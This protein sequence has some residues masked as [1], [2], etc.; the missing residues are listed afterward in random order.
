MSLT[1][2][3]V[4]LVVAG[5]VAGV[6]TAGSLQ[7]GGLMADD[8]A[9]PSHR[10]DAPPSPQHD[11]NLKTIGGRT[12]RKVS[13]VRERRARTPRLIREPRIARQP[14]DPQQM[15]EERL[16]RHERWL[17][18]SPAEAVKQKSAFIDIYDPKA[19]TSLLQAS[20]NILAK[21]EP[22]M[23]GDWGALN[24][25][26]K[27][28]NP[29][30]MIYDTIDSFV[31]NLDGSD[32]DS[33]VQNVFVNPFKETNSIGEGFKAMGL[34]F[35]MAAGTDLDFLSNPIKGALA[36]GWRGF[37]RGLGL[38]G[39]GR[40]VYN[41]NIK[42]G[43]AT[44]DFFANLGMEL[45]VS[46]PTVVISS[47]GTAAKAGAK[48]TT[49]GAKQ[50]AKEVAQET[51]ERIVSVSAQQAA[52]EI[53]K[54]LTE[55]AA[56]QIIKQHG[57]EAVKGGV[58]ALQ[59]QAIEILAD[60]LEKELIKQLS[61]KT[62]KAT[63]QKVAI[64]AGEEAIQKVAKESGEQVLASA[65]KAVMNKWI[66]MGI[67]MSID[68]PAYKLVARATQT[69]S[70]SSKFL[71]MTTQ[72]IH[73]VK[74]TKAFQLYRF[75]EALMQP[76]R[77]WNKF[78]ADPISGFFLNIY[79]QPFKLAGTVVGRTVSFLPMTIRGN[80]TKWITE[81]P[82]IAKWIGRGAGGIANT[83]WAW[84][85]QNRLYKQ[86][87]EWNKFL[88]NI[89]NIDAYRQLKDILNMSSA[90]ME[91]STKA[92]L[93]LNGQMVHKL[94]K[95]APNRGQDTVQRVLKRSFYEDVNMYREIA[96]K[97]LSEL[98]QQTNEK[99]VTQFGLAQT[100]MSAE[101]SAFLQQKY[102]LNY[103]Q[104]LSFLNEIHT[105]DNNLDDILSMFEF[106]DL[107]VKNR[108]ALTALDNIEPVIISGTMTSS[109]KIEITSKRG[110]KQSA[111]EVAR[112][113]QVMK[114]SNNFIREEK[115]FTETN[116][117]KIP[118]TAEVIDRFIS[119]DQV[120]QYQ[121]ALDSFHRRFIEV[122]NMRSL[123]DKVNLFTKHIT[124]N[125]K[126]IDANA[127]SEAF[128]TA[129]YNL[130]MFYRT[131]GDD[132]ILARNIASAWI[133]EAQ[134]VFNNKYILEV[135][136][137]FKKI[138][139][140]V[141]GA[142]LS[143]QLTEQ[144]SAH[145]QLYLMTLDPQS[146]I[147]KTLS[148]FDNKRSFERYL[149]AAEYQ[150]K[151][152]YI[153]QI[154]QKYGMT[155][156]QLSEI[157]GYA[158]H[159][160]N[161]TNMML[162]DVKQNL[163]LIPELMRTNNVAEIA[164]VYSKV[165]SSTREL[166]TLIGE[167]ASDVLGLHVKA[168]RDGFELQKTA[169]RTQGNPKF[170]A[171]EAAR[172]T[173]ITELATQ[174]NIAVMDFAGQIK[175]QR[176]K[177]NQME[178]QYY[179]FNTFQRGGAGLSDISASKPIV[180]Q[181]GFEQQYLDLQ[182]QLRD[183]QIKINQVPFGTESAKLELQKAALESQLRKVPTDIEHKHLNA[184]RDN[185]ST[186]LNKIFRET[187]IDLTPAQL[188]EIVDSITW[189][190]FDRIRGI[191]ET[192][193]LPE[194]MRPSTR[195]GS[196]LRQ[197]FG[198]HLSDAELL[199]LRDLWDKRTT[200]QALRALRKYKP[201]ITE[202]ALAKIITGREQVIRGGLDEL[203]LQGT[204]A[205]RPIYAKNLGEMVNSEIM[206][207]VG[208]GM[209]ANDIA[210]S[211]F[212]DK[213]RNSSA[214]PR[215]SRSLSVG[216]AFIRRSTEGDIIE[217]GEGLIVGAAI[218]P[219]EQTILTETELLLRQGDPATW[220]EFFVGAKPSRERISIF[221]T[222][223]G[224]IPAL[225]D[226]AGWNQY[227][228]KFQNK[229]RK[230]ALAETPSIIVAG[231]RIPTG[232]PLSVF[233]DARDNQLML[234]IND[235]YWNMDMMWGHQLSMNP[236]EAMNE[237]WYTL[238]NRH[239]DLM[240]DL[241]I[242]ATTQISATEI[243][244]NITETAR[245]RIASAR[246]DLATHAEI[247]KVPT[248]ISGIER[249]LQSIRQ[250][251][252]A[253]EIDPIN[254][255]KQN[256]LK[257][258]T[259]NEINQLNEQS[260]LL[261]A[262]IARLRG[263][264]RQFKTSLRTTVELEEVIMRYE[265]WLKNIDD[266]VEGVLKNSIWPH[267][268]AF[269]NSRFKN[270]LQDLFQDQIGFKR[271]QGDSTFV[272]QDL[273][274]TSEILA[275]TSGTRVNEMGQTL[276][277]SSQLPIA[278][279]SRFQTDKLT[280]AQ[281]LSDAWKTEAIT[282]R[283][284]ELGMRSA[285]R[286]VY[287]EAEY[288]T[289]VKQLDEIISIRTDN[290]GRILDMSDISEV[291]QFLAFLQTSQ[292]LA[293]NTIITR[294]AT[295]NT[296]AVLRAHSQ[297]INELWE[298]FRKA[299]N[300]PENL[301][302]EYWQL[303][304]NS[305][306]NRNSVIKYGYMQSLLTLRLDDMNVNLVRQMKAQLNAAVSDLKTTPFG[307][308]QRRLHDFL[309][310]DSPI[311]SRDVVPGAAFSRVPE[312]EHRI[313][314]LSP[315]KD[316][317]VNFAV[318]TKEMAGAEARIKSVKNLNDLAALTGDNAWLRS[319]LNDFYKT[320]IRDEVN[321]HF[322]MIK[323]EELTILPKW[324]QALETYGPNNPDPSFRIFT[325]TDFE[326]FESWFYGTNVNDDT[327]IKNFKILEKNIE[328]YN[329]QLYR[330][331]EALELIKRNTMEFTRDKWKYQKE[332]L[333]GARTRLDEVQLYLD[334]TAK[335]R[336]MREAEAAADR[337]RL[338]SGG[339]HPL[340]LAEERIGE[341]LY[342]VEQDLA[343]SPYLNYW[344]HD[345]G[346]KRAIQNLRD[347]FEQPYTIRETSRPALRELTQSDRAQEL[348]DALQNLFEATGNVDKTFKEL[349]R[350]IRLTPE[351]LQKSMRITSQ[352]ILD[353]EKIILEHNSFV[354]HI[355]SGKNILTDAD[356][357]YKM[358]R[359]NQR[360]SEAYQQVYNTSMFNRQAWFS[361]NYRQ[362]ALNIIKTLPAE[363]GV[364]DLQ[365]LLNYREQQQAAFNLRSLTTTD[366]NDP[367]LVN[368]T[369]E[370]DHLDKIAEAYRYQGTF[371][372][373]EFINNVAEFQK[374]YAAMDGHSL[375][376]LNNPNL[377]S[378]SANESYIRALG[379][380]PAIRGGKVIPGDPL[381]FSEVHKAFR[382]RQ[383]GF[384]RNADQFIAG[385]IKEIF[386]K[387]ADELA[388]HLAFTGPFN[389]FQ[390]SYIRRHPEIYSANRWLGPNGK[391]TL[392][393][394][395]ELL[396]K[397][398][399]VSYLPQQDLMILTLEKS[400]MGYRR[401]DNAVTLNG[402][403]IERQWT[404][405]SL[406]AEGWEQFSQIVNNTTGTR[407]GYSFGDQV[408]N[409]FYSRLFTGTKK[410]FSGF[411]NSRGTIET[412]YDIGRRSR[413][414]Q[415]LLKE[416]YSPEA[417]T[418]KG[419]EL[420]RR[421]AKVK[422]LAE[423]LGGWSNE[424][425]VSGFYFPE[426]RF[427]E[428]IYGDSDFAKRFGVYR[429]TNPSVQ[430]WDRSQDLM[431]MNKSRTNL[432]LDMLDDAYDIGGAGV[433]AKFTDQQIYDFL[434]GPIGRDY[435]LAV[436]RSGGRGQG[437]R[438]APWMPFNGVKD[439][440]RARELH[441][442]LIP[443]TIYKRA[444]MTL[445]SRI[446]NSTMLHLWHRMH[447]WYKTLILA[448]NAGGVVIDNLIDT[449]LKTYIE[450]SE[451][452]NKVGYLQA[453]TIYNEYQDIL[454]YFSARGVSGERAMEQMFLRNDLG[455][456]SRMRAFKAMD[457]F[458]GKSSW[459][460][461][462]EI[463]DFFT[464]GPVQGISTSF[465]TANELNTTLRAKIDQEYSSWL[466]NI[467]QGAQ[468]KIFGML[469]S[470]QGNTEQVN[471]LSMYLTG[472]KNQ[473]TIEQAYGWVRRTH[474]D[475]AFKTGIERTLEQIVPFSSF[476]LRSMEYWW[477]VIE[478]NPRIIQ[479]LIMIN[480]ASWAANDYDPEQLSFLGAFP[481]PVKLF[482]TAT[483]MDMMLK[484]TPGS[485]GQVFDTF[486]NPENLKY[487]I[488]L[489][490]AQV[491]INKLSENYKGENNWDSKSVADKI[492]TASH[493]LPGT[494]TVIKVKNFI[495]NLEKE[496][497]AGAVH[498]VPGL[499]VTAM[500][501]K[502]I[503]Y[504]KYKPVKQLRYIN[505]QRSPTRLHPLRMQQQR[506]HIRTGALDIMQGYNVKINTNPAKIWF[507]SGMNKARVNTPQNQFLNRIQTRKKSA[508]LYG[509]H[510]AAFR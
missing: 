388:E 418:A 376:R 234:A 324:K 414:E 442:R 103:D 213:L 278:E 69:I 252:R 330:S 44:G 444:A 438:V 400:R 345:A 173:A 426:R 143:Q 48:L 488:A 97:H 194:F 162:Q 139:A 447:S 274:D 1:L 299:V 363:E 188:Q 422:T 372:P 136:L 428:M 111:D 474:F 460:A 273:I 30:Q 93:S 65:Q 458:D 420:E 5:T 225:D 264:E 275:R 329:G 228:K 190:S 171:D 302:P 193:A 140:T 240:K 27:W 224:P 6:A 370:L 226:K 157:E 17:E 221:E 128:K 152:D 155:P 206:N 70:Q 61:K 495:E 175:M 137:D 336:A 87:R 338:P 311:M 383:A 305:V 186:R 490:G 486:F 47:A 79:K 298:I 312:L 50:A 316:A 195:S 7:D 505:N 94:N 441:A 381:K 183:I 457:I 244:D 249:Q 217:V 335:T 450:T 390:P 281:L 504:V 461:F 29:A 353:V 119:A 211:D 80:F 509:I 170:I 159:L 419:I 112:Q 167:D 40:Y 427:N 358:I 499:G 153:T 63:M 117:A 125:V 205:S 429:T 339:E 4:G 184:I 110:M 284:Q 379:V 497:I 496:D 163:D 403:L 165:V 266:M 214:A 168:I 432:T 341:V 133:E 375:I 487:R 151:L 423:E 385:N 58:R 158:R 317:D 68:S 89:N 440:T 92:A 382:Q 449:N 373:T 369:R 31:W 108:G 384:I 208:R 20:A 472:I 134:R 455:L 322:A 33:L 313:G 174:E 386:S 260:K 434:Q 201:E 42:T 361:Q 321:L 276:M 297:E 197:M 138:I 314:D 374:L 248:E 351:E 471:R 480:K 250:Q 503:P 430:A 132:S 23:L 121:D 473:M 172:K 245:A 318:I 251:I 453:N 359:Q 26:Q 9:S 177:I 74:G 267:A 231:E 99:I 204:L 307:S 279:V 484:A 71:E 466:R 36:D 51:T 269:G 222:Y 371:N 352:E 78:I 315:L 254:L 142:S 421:T 164:D 150:S 362:E 463:N 416:M 156:A 199:A 288:N 325:Q 130:D 81:G 408:N 52:K 212:L 215:D 380:T 62:V 154:G 459:E 241:D 332:I 309:R 57:K 392:Q 344:G 410:G 399:H 365:R 489:P 118:T 479:R 333:E 424:D 378:L 391:I 367:L 21:D 236:S 308:K 387:T 109:H 407:L 337:V 405:R 255:T 220:R 84:L 202:E 257:V 59:K 82:G 293:E 229:A 467:E 104:Y 15:R 437:L 14:R 343:S 135:P 72:V 160:P 465:K 13:M 340:D 46:L 395:A 114:D 91:D 56:R 425:L 334:S 191:M 101:W 232:T 492:L 100:N 67:D 77:V 470:L 435:V 88:K 37:G 462:K 246:A 187:K 500:R 506:V 203:R 66:K 282:M 510:I 76:G 289:F 64:E 272:A 105:L 451:F 350:I 192:Q 354:A 320:A 259:I 96:E 349:D 237:F 478:T 402:S 356:P 141:D 219:L 303:L 258:R 482:T 196:M 127:M 86:S 508:Q 16:G 270:A 73:A 11:P 182:L 166:K 475:Y 493:W 464:Y 210:V 413:K 227:I 131:A 346:V 409:E 443:M 436:T 286:Q 41:F 146:S 397:G 494:A 393:A 55:D 123:L 398:I 102:Q 25:L 300:N 38:T 185:L 477:H 75:G 209:R 181:L 287:G 60:D 406:T 198:E 439:I 124:I 122:Q 263:Y 216:E 115:L 238:Q 45:L 394:Q 502:Y 291:E 431:M 129:F 265:A 326:T 32:Q 319:Q 54:Q 377:L 261:N 364:T 145:T 355:N 19:N 85:T 95:I 306:D 180:T 22:G 294:K 501:R 161:V 296:S 106:T 295:R 433:Y 507:L 207:E 456:Q 328:R 176:A 107:A 389:F 454:A 3:I 49:K 256:K 98:A 233:G 401:I 491:L 366:A 253:I 268:D 327:F 147:V 368:L 271:F 200:E 149:R 126:G 415:R 310:G 468:E 262:D 485:F 12:Y 360:L 412:I 280:D 292:S 35:L 498:Q 290:F 342:Q 148:R 348:I 39:E 230:Q 178:S 483:G 323:N 446:S 28:V 189:T 90:F 452:T 448:T 417:M 120:A 247:L 301:I 283:E 243:R 357:I 347:T 223:M 53:G 469:T 2:L 277:D 476:L 10:P 8:M 116:P 285:L 242:Q 169:L 304:I 411:D 34:N 404:Q 18:L 83:T 179:L 481:S 445:N 24:F 239:P 218:D 144:L 331:E 43:N 396:E 235:T 113:Q